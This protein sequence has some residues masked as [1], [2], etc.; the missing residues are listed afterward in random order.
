MWCLCAVAA[1]V[2][3]INASWSMEFQAMARIMGHGWRADP[4]RGLL[5]ALRLTPIWQIARP[6][7]LRVQP[8]IV[9]L[10][11]S[12]HQKWQGR[13]AWRTFSTWLCQHITKMR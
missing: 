2:D 10:E 4:T 9:L 5:T 11:L 8:E 6:T 3:D 7:H 1:N 13:L 12:R